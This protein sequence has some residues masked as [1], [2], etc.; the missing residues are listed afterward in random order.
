[1]HNGQQV[2]DADNHVHPSVEA[3]EP[4]FEAEFH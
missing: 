1:M 2:F 3:L 4:Y